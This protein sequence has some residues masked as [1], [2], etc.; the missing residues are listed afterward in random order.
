MIKLQVLDNSLGSS[1]KAK[2][3]THFTL[4]KKMDFESTAK[5]YKSH[6]NTSLQ[7]ILISH[8]GYF[9]QKY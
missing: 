4:K 2:L 6:Q 5:A 8:K 3:P 9:I 7:E 1:V